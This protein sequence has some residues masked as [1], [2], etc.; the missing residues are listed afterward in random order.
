MSGVTRGWGTQ[1]DTRG[2]RWFTARTAFSGNA[3]L[4]GRDRH[5]RADFHGT[6]YRGDE[7]AFDIESMRSLRKIPA[8]CLTD[9]DDW[10]RNSPSFPNKFYS[11]RARTETPTHSSFNISSIKLCRFLVEKNKIPL[12]STFWRD[13]PLL[14]IYILTRMHVA[15]AFYSAKRQYTP[16]NDKTRWF[17][18][19]PRDSSIYARMCIRGPTFLPGVSRVSRKIPV[20]GEPRLALDATVSLFKADLYPRYI[21]LVVS[22]RTARSLYRVVWWPTIRSRR[23]LNFSSVEYV[24]H[25][26]TN[27]F[28]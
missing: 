27:D 22:E 15:I 14:P 17:R 20:I 24:L 7:L 13:T 9:G 2:Y 4:R 8:K 26:A 3:D 19:F 5:D 18:C 28:W 6:P 16:V 1:I 11:C 23:M 12:S 25:R 10:Y 21:S